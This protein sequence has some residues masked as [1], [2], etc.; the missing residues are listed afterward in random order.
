MTATKLTHVSTN[1]PPPPQ[2]AVE[3]RTENAPAKAQGSFI[4]NHSRA[5]T[6]ASLVGL[7]MV[8]A[9]LS[10]IEFRGATSPLRAEDVHSNDRC[11]V[12][13][14]FEDQGMGQGPTVD[15]WKSIWERAGWKPVVLHEKHAALHPDYDDMKSRFATFP[16]TNS[17][18][19]EVACYLRYLAMSMVGGGY[20]T[21]YDTINVNVPPPPGCEFLPS[22]GKLT[23]HDDFVPAMVS[24]T[25]QEFERVI[26]DMH[27]T[28]LDETMAA[29]GQSMVSDMYF[30]QYFI[31]QGK[32]KV[33][34]NFYSS[35]NWMADPPC[36][37]KGNELPLMFHLN[38]DKVASEFG[39]AGKPEV[40]NEWLDK[41]NEARA[42][43]NPVTVE[44]EEQYVKKFLVPL[45]TNKF[46]E[47][48]W[49]HWNCKHAGTCND[50]DNKASERL[51]HQA[52]DKDGRKVDQTRLGKRFEGRLGER[53]QVVR[54]ENLHKLW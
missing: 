39:G 23:T 51:I 1:T 9:A 28:D 10:T 34:H 15:A 26:Q 4:A 8:S 33:A 44:T 21:D 7:V 5:L 12:Y 25:E 52:V 17:A 36:D 6:L 16:T 19:Y 40:M 54:K 35:P 32:V 41:L 46:V 20:M 49:S 18:G 45:G 29:V 53:E 31:Q 50:P 2:V 14:Y 37:E 42:K 30:L 13:T 27:S 24:G 22:N 38:T 43:C 48:L 3:V 11:I 47:A